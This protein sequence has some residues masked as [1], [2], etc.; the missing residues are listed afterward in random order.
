MSRRLGLLFGLLVASSALVGAP[1]L[2]GV[3]S[4][5][6]SVPQVLTIGSRC[7]A[8]MALDENPLHTATYNKI[9]LFGGLDQTGHA[10]AGTFKWTGT[11]WED[12]NLAGPCARKS[13]RMAY[14]P[15]SSKLVL[16]GGRA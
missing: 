15:A 10:Q 8:G 2:G 7:C 14:D 16:F 5:G 1:G 12:L 3:S 4:A 11:A 13:T 9:V 6:P